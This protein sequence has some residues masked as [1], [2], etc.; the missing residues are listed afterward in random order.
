MSRVGGAVRNARSRYAP[1]STRRRQHS[2]HNSRSGRSLA[3]H[4]GR[5]ARYCAHSRHR[6]TAQSGYSLPDHETAAPPATENSRRNR[7]CQVSL[8]ANC[9]GAHPLYLRNAVLNALADSYPMSSA[10]RS[11]DFVPRARASFAIAIRQRAR[12]SIGAHPRASLNRAENADLDMPAMLARSATV[13]LAR[14]SA[15]TAFKARANAGSCKPRRIPAG[16]WRSTSCQRSASTRSTS[17]MR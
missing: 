8:R 9:P 3:K 12:Y 16:T 6:M 5:A 4:L 14:T 7:E 1:A 2:G 11:R 10:I 13:Q 17:S 15:W